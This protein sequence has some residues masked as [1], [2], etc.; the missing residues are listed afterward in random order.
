MYT[1]LK[2]EQLGL[3][4][5]ICLEAVCSQTVVFFVIV[6]KKVKDSKL[7]EA[8][9]AV[10]FLHIEYFFQCSLLPFISTSSYQVT[11]ILGHPYEKGR[12]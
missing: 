1:A 8:V 12:S 2:R 9:K 3:S 6:L 5:S 4:S 10:N 11:A 7:V